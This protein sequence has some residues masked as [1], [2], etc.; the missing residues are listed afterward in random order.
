[1]V[2]L[3]NDDYWKRPEGGQ[4]WPIR[5]ENLLHN[6]VQV[7]QD[8]TS[9]RRVGLKKMRAPVRRSAVFSQQYVLLVY[10]SI[11]DGIFSGGGSSHLYRSVRDATFQP[12]P[13]PHQT[14][15][16]QSTDSRRLLQSPCAVHRRW[17]R[18]AACRRGPPI[19]S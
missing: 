15:Y 3:R 5:S 13:V 4:P 11:Q 16:A 7:G 17:Y 8:D 19:G 6:S 9:H 10:I 18:T 2:V 12:M 1:M 14:D